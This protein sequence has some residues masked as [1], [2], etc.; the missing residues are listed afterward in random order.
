MPLDKVH[1]ASERY[2][3]L[4]LQE[5]PYQSPSRDGSS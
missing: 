1:S 3:F 2:L 5:Q 4:R